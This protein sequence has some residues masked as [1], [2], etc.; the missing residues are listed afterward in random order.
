MRTSEREGW[1]EGWRR[2][3]ELLA[4]HYPSVT[5]LLG[6]CHGYRDS[7][8][9]VL[10]TIAH[11]GGIQLWATM[12]TPPHHHHHP[13]S[14]L[15]SLCLSHLLFLHLPPVCICPHL[16]AF[17]HI[18]LSVLLFCFFFCFSLNFTNR[19]PAITRPT[20]ASSHCLALASHSHLQLHKRE[21]GRERNY[22]QTQSMKC[23]FPNCAEQVQTASD[24][25]EWI[26]ALL[27]SSREANTWFENVLFG[28]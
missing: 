20:A 16:F 18:Y 13:F 4:H 19:N 23:Y 22:A 15:L 10:L 12:R 2:E 17:K 3:K 1:R 8:L 11:K 24:T 27:R 26:T 7:R 21:R 6:S 28:A 5:G 25:S 14:P 9:S